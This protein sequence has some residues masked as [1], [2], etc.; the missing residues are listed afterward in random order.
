MPTELDKTEKRRQETVRNV[1]ERV[2]YVRCELAE[3]EF[4]GETEPTLIWTKEGNYDEFVEESY[5]WT[6]TVLPATTVF[7]HFSRGYR[8]QQMP[9]VLRA[10]FSRISA[11]NNNTRCTINRIVVDNDAYNTIR[12][13]SAPPLHVIRCGGACRISDTRFIRRELDKL[14]RAAIAASIPV[15]DNSRLH[16]TYVRA[17]RSTCPGRTISRE[18]KPSLARRPTR[19]FPESQLYVLLYI[20]RTYTRKNCHP[21]E[22]HAF[23][24][25][26]FQVPGSL[27]GQLGH[28]RR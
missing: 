1:Y 16:N 23:T 26:V 11:N 22:G 15:Y 8:T 14:S 12:Q 21:R 27:P 24:W 25:W 19:A 3:W 28:I 17:P 10:C 7:E 5:I 18:K 9:P 20:A 6:T 13:R 2:T 4:R